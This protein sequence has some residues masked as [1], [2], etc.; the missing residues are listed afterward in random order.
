ME[1]RPSASTAFCRGH[2]ARLDHLLRHGLDFGDDDSKNAYAGVLRWGAT[3]AM[4]DEDFTWLLRNRASEGVE[5]AMRLACMGLLADWENSEDR[6]ALIAAGRSVT[7][8][9]EWASD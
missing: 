5:P 9:P 1:Q 8:F 3:H 7:A 6:T 4:P 2:L